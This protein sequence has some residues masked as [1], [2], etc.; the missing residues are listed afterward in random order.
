MELRLAHVT[1]AEALARLEE[2]RI[3]ACSVNS[4]REVLQDRTISAAEPFHPLNYPGIDETVPVVKAPVFLS[5]TPPSIERRPPQLGEHTDEVL[6]E[7]GY[8]PE[9]IASLR[10]LG[11]V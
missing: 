11:V 5:R 2:A 1:R 8:A 7:L 3:P 10:D 6:R 4:P 9:R